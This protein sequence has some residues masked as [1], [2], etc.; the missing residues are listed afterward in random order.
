MEQTSSTKVTPEEKLKLET[1]I[2]ALR[3]DFKY[4]TEDLAKLKKETGVLVTL[5]T[6]VTTE[7]AE[8][9]EELTKVKNQISQEKLEWATFRGCQLKELEDKESEADNVIKRKGELNE[10]EEAI[11]KVEASAIDARNEARRLELKNEQTAIDFDNRE[12]QIAVLKKEAED[13]GVKNEKDRKVFL[14]RIIK[15]LEEVKEI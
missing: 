6:K 12:K 11:R 2:F 14:A 4:A 9:E 5:K 10:Q 1:D 15:L 13:V 3:R 7:I 8:N